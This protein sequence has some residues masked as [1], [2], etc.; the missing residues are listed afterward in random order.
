MKT[1]TAKALQPSR[2]TALTSQPEASRALACSTSF[3]HAASW[4]GDSYQATLINSSISF[5]QFTWVEKL[6]S[7]INLFRNL[8]FD[9]PEKRPRKPTN[10]GHRYI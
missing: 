4:R 3:Q 9:L 8:L 5:A 6:T 7:Q 1:A 10:E 2:P